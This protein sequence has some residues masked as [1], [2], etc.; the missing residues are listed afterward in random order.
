MLF[1]CVHPSVAHVQTLAFC[2]LA[3]SLVMLPAWAGIA[4]SNLSAERKAKHLRE[5]SWIWLRRWGCW[6]I[7]NCHCR[8]HEAASISLR[9]SDLS[10]TF[11]LFACRICKVTRREVPG[12]CTRTCMR[13][14]SPLRP[15]E[16]SFPL[17]GGCT[18]K[19]LT[20]TRKTLQCIRLSLC[21]VSSAAQILCDKVKLLNRFC[22]DFAWYESWCEN[23]F[24]LRKHH[25]QKEQRIWTASRLALASFVFSRLSPPNVAN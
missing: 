14:Y 21:L 8:L 1:R 9:H 25:G 18:H 7:E 13:L 16:N 15:F 19:C 4:L 23:V 3:S 20:L 5:A 22:L 2:V 10:R 24:L 12:Q 17:F 6:M 11:C